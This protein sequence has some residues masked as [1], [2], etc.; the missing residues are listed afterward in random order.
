MGYKQ[1]PKEIFTLKNFIEL[2]ELIGNLNN[3]IKNLHRPKHLTS[4]FILIYA[5]PLPKEDHTLNAGVLAP[6]CII[7]GSHLNNS[8]PNMKIQEVL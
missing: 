5:C 6:C 3:N 8:I 2:F 7:P 4:A 1:F